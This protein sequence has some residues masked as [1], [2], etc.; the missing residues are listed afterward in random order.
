MKQTAL[1]QH[2]LG[3]IRAD[4]VVVSILRKRV[5]EPAVTASAV[6]MVCP[7]EKCDASQLNRKGCAKRFS[8]ATPF[9]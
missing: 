6:R 5:E 7:T 3:E 2:G 8:L 4:R 9:Q 1:S